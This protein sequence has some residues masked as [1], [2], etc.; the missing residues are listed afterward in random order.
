[1]SGLRHGG[2]RLAGAAILSCLAWRCELIAVSAFAGEAYITCYSL[3]ENS[4]SLIVSDLPTNCR[5]YLQ[6]ITDS[7]TLLFVVL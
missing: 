3:Q 2:G 4:P 1:M 7:K 6:T 5:A